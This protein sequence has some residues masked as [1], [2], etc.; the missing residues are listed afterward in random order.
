MGPFLGDKNVKLT[1][2]V[3][4]VSCWRGGLPSRKLYARVALWFR[5]LAALKPGVHVALTRH[6]GSDR[7]IFWETSIFSAVL[8]SKTQ[9]GSR[10]F[11]LRVSYFYRGD[12]VMS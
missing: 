10:R 2:R 3:I 1:A 12:G 5:T 6:L 11:L 8:Q 9:T 4:C 7:P